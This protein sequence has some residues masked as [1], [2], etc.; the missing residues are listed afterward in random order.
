[1]C[2]LPGGSLGWI[3]ALGSTFPFFLDELQRRHTRKMRSF[4]ATKS[5]LQDQRRKRIGWSMD[6]MNE[7][8]FLYWT[9]RFSSCFS[10]PEVFHRNLFAEVKSKEFHLIFYLFLTCS[11]SLSGHASKLLPPGKWTCNENMIK[12]SGWATQLRFPTKTGIVIWFLGKSST[13]E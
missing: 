7:D 6:R 5:T 4:W 2:T 13:F 11:T 1:M 3:V 12:Q 10:L 9:C 8:A